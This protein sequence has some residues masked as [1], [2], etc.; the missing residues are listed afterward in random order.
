MALIPFNSEGG[1]S[2][3]SEEIITIVTANGNATPVNLAVSGESNLGNVA[4][5]TITGG[6]NGQVLYTDGTGNL[7]WKS[8][9]DN[10]VVGLRDGSM[11]VV[12]E[13]GILTIVG[14]SG[15]I[16]VPISS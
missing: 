1:F 13:N 14:R 16:P 15:N 7:G 6:S 9:T 12:L 2:V 8:I 10:L 11:T 5:V 3:G 4:N